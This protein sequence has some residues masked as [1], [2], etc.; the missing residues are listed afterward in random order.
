MAF[1][2]FHRFRKHQK[3]YFAILTI[4]CML[5]FVLQF[6]AGDPFQRL[7]GW[8]GMGRN[9]GEKVTALYGKSVYQRD[10]DELKRQRVLASDFL[11]AGSWSYQRDALMALRK[12]LEPQ[13][14]TN[15]QEEPRNPLVRAIDQ[16]L[17]GYQLLFGQRFQIPPETLRQL[18]NPG[19]QLRALSLQLSAPGLEKNPDQ[20]KDLQIVM[21]ALAFQAWITSPAHPPG[22][23]YFG[24]TRKVDDLLDFLVWKH[25]ADR[26]GIVLTPA[27]VCKEV[28]K[29]W[30]GRDVVQEKGFDKTEAVRTYLRSN[31]ANKNA[32]GQDL[33]NALI[34]E[35]RVQLAKEAV[36][37]HGDGVRAVLASFDE[38]HDSPAVATPDEFLKYYRTQRTTLNVDLGAV[39]V[40]RY[41]KDVTTT[42][43]EEALRILYEEY[44]EQEPAPDRRQ[45]GFK[46]PRRVR[47]AYFSH[48]PN[49]EYYKK[50]AAEWAP[51]TPAFAVGLPANAYAA[52]GGPAAWATQLVTPLAFD[53]RVLVPYQAYITKERENASLGFQ[54]FGVGVNLNDRQGL[55]ALGAAALL[56][57]AAGD[58]LTG[59]SPLGAP[60]AALAAN[61]VYERLTLQAFGSTVL[62]A[63]SPSPLVAASLPARFVHTPLPLEAVRAQML[64]R[65]QRELASAMEKDNFVKLTK[66]LEKLKNSPEKMADY[67]AKAVKE[68][69]FENYHIMEHARSRQEVLDD[70]GALQELKTAWSE[71]HKDRPFAELV[72]MLFEGN[73]VGQPLTRGVFQTKDGETYVAFRVEDRPPRVRPFAEVRDQVIHAWKL[74]QARA[75]AR[76]EARRIN[77]ELKERHAGPDDAV[78]FLREQKGVEIIP[79]NDVCHLR[80]LQDVAGAGRVPEYRPYQVPEDKIKYPLPDFVTRL[81]QLQEPGQSE[82]LWDRPQMH[83]YVAVLRERIVPTMKEFTELYSVVPQSDQLWQMMMDEKHR[84]FY[85]DLMKQLRAEAGKVDEDGNWIIPESIR[86]RSE[87]VVDTGE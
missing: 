30:G 77:D 57:Q 65:F 45:P 56:G 62:A 20:L 6:G 51:R 26:L 67:L 41:L 53:V 8:I 73:E 24:G 68:D 35:Y 13:R 32:S 46:D 15:P 19:E 42:P 38:V 16:W 87:S 9:R 71:V 25:E 34:E 31:Q 43:S 1:N 36:L 48:N 33:M 44:K 84:E 86:N 66:E 27:E 74:E 10:L 17:F 75:D 59:A 18:I 49:S 80:K 64:E 7:L 11:V 50:Q 60:A 2:P 72:A 21:H 4:V 83:F 39:S 54:P 3:V 52:G 69:H 78:R 63:A 82:L 12:V 81:L 5:V 55:Q 37:G 70:P 61:A 22:E 79:L 29:A 28:N 23:S 85:Q 47:I 14:P 76:R 58:G 40:E